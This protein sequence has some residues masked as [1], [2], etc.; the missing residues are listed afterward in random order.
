MERSLSAAEEL[1]EHLLPKGLADSTT[2]TRSSGCICNSALRPRILEG[3]FRTT[4]GSAKNAY[5]L[6]R[7]DRHG[8]EP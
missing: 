1:P 5:E 2:R 6:S 7:H 4:K 8:N 3:Y